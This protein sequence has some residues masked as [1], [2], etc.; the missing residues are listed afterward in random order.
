MYIDEAGVFTAI[1]V[2]LIF[3]IIGYVGGLASG[4]P[5][6]MALIIPLVLAG[7]VIT[8]V[9]GSLILTKLVMLLFG[10]WIQ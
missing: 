9:G 6:K 2:L 3:S 5:I 7:I 8:L 4:N 1:C 10:E